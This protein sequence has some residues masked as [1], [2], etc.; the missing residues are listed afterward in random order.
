MTSCSRTDALHDDIA[1]VKTV[2]R[3]ALEG[4]STEDTKAMTHD[5]VITDADLAYHKRLI[6]H[7]EGAYETA[8]A[9]NDA[10]PHTEK[11]RKTT[12][13]IAK[14]RHQALLTPRSS[15]RVKELKSVKRIRAAAKEMRRK[16]TGVDTL[17][18]RVLEELPD[19]LLHDLCIILRFMLVHVTVP[20]TQ[21]Q[22]ILVGTPK[23]IRGEMRCFNIHFA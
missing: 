8:Q 16:A 17:P 13:C 4:P 22:A 5:Q 9:R 20:L 6:K 11:W 2:E 7:W 14:Y 15:D 3:S 10:W 19:N 1:Y 12:H 18:F 23:K 21:L